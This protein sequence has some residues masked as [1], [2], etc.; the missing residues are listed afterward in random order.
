MRRVAFYVIVCLVMLSSISGAIFAQ[1]GG[2]SQVPPPGFGAPPPDR[3]VGLTVTSDQVDDGYILVSIIQSKTPVLLTREGRIVQMWDN[4]NYM[5]Q[6]VYLLPNGN[7]LR[8]TSLPDYA[9]GSG[10]AWG[11]INNRLQ[12]V[13]WEGEVVWSYDFGDDTIVGHHDIEP[14]PNGH[15]LIIAF[16]RF[17][18]EEALANGLNPEILS[19][20][21]GH[22]EI[23]D[24]HAA[25]TIPG[26]R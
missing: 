4:E 11:F 23:P 8:T 18:A 12:E 20:E 15:I 9:Y 22:H 14:M 19:D 17:S 10:G 21:D 3:P 6:S 7:L 16:E 13:N 25:I 2:D 24:R 26:P 5:G 1:D